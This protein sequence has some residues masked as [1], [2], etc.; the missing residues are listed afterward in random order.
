MSNLVPKLEIEFDLE[1]D[2]EDGEDV[3]LLEKCWMHLTNGW[4]VSISSRDLAPAICSVCA[5]P[6]TEDNSVVQ[7]DLKTWFWFTRHSQ[8]YRCY[9]V[10]CVRKALA[11]VEA[12]P[13]PPQVLPVTNDDI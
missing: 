1:S 7:A 2:D 12:A 10:E 5:W 4:T 11:M 3:P 13:P 6:S 8:E 9:S